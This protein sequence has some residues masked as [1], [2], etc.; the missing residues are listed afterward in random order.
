MI[1]IIFFTVLISIL[2]SAYAS[3]ND[4]DNRTVI[5]LKPAD[6]NVVLAE[7]RLFLTSVQQITKGVSES[8]IALVYTAARLSGRAAQGAVPPS[9]V[10]SLPQ[11]FKRVALDT[12]MQFDQ[13]AIDA[14]DLG[15]SNYSSTQLAK[16]MEN[17]IS[18]HATYRFVEK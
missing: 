13:L 15:D 3:E 4:K 2:G 9:L 17:C 12:H 10:K 11:A 6:R 1:K 7:M 16:L 14:K 18:C 5:L 8:D